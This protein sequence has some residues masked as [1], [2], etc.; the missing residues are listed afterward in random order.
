MFFS[1]FDQLNDLLR[2]DLYCTTNF[3]NY[4]LFYHWQEPEVFQPLGF[5]FT[6]LSDVFMDARDPLVANFQASCQV[7]NHERQELL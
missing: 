3:S 6:Y 1:L 4:H 7:S 5:L 2:A